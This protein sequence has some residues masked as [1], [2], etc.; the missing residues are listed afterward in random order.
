MW[1]RSYRIIECNFNFEMGVKINGSTVTDLWGF[2]GPLF[3]RI[4][5]FKLY[6]NG[7][8]KVVTGGGGFI[9]VRLKVKD[10]I[11]YVQLLYSI[12]FI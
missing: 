10:N 6:M 7:K 2:K 5:C 4:F 3:F 11:K 1:E 9:G 8:Q 12:N